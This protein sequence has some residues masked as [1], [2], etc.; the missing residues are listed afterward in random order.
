[1]TATEAAATDP[2]Q[3][4]LLEVSYE[5]LENAGLSLSAV[6]GSDM[7]CFVGSFSSEYGDI[8]SRDLN[9]RPVYAATGEGTALLSNRLSWFYD[10]R[11]PSATLDT[12]CSASLVAL[13]LACDGIRS[14]KNRTRT[15]LVGGSALMLS[16][17]TMTGVS[18]MHFLSPDS[19]CYSFDE[20]ANGY[21]RGEGIGVLVLKHVED[22]I[23]DGDTIRAVIR[24]TA[25]N[26]AQWLAAT[27]PKIQGTWNL[28]NALPK[29]LDF[30]IMLSS[31]TG[32]I[33]T[34]G[35]SNYAAGNTFLDAFATYRRGLG[36]RAQAID[37]G[38]VTGI[39]F[40]EENMAQDA[41]TQLNHFSAIHINEDTFLSIFKMA[42]ISYSDVDGAHELPPQLIVGVGT[43]GLE[44]LNTATQHG[45]DFPWLRNFASFAHLRSLDTEGSEMTSILDATSASLNAQ[46]Q[47]VSTQQEAHDLIQD[48]L[49]KKI[50]KAI[51][52]DGK[53]IDTSKA[54][55]H[56][57]VDS[58]V[59]VGVRNWILR[60]LK[61]DISVFEILAEHPMAELVGVVVR[62]CKILPKG[63]LSEEE[64]EL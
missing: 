34:P 35:Q 5:S 7:A 8:S 43:G 52:I 13:H 36:L 61:S 19:R 30:F 50:A 39:G 23:R 63:L 57:G 25:V 33:G 53:D 32:I 48:E 41:Q 6:A 22:A 42:L 12:G 62:R 47:S 21:G 37:M 17:F 56:Y 1:M 10:L 11:G 20:R 29:Q 24:G 14:T 58:L 16:P 4:L 55:H 15:A 51:M 18:A 40:F 49:V 27:R 2:Q 59:A 3:R 54:L 60:E 44:K 31:C 38:I 28:H 64:Y 26:H 45:R 9:T 46:L